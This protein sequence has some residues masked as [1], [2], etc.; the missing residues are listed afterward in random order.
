MLRMKPRR[1]SLVL[2][3]AL[4]AAGAAAVAWWRWHPL[5]VEVVHPQ[6]GTAIDAVYATGIV[7]PTIAVPIAPRVAGRIVS[8]NVDEGA[9]VRRGQVL[10]R[11]EDADLRR[12]QDELDAR[13]RYA[14]Q[15]LERAQTLLQRGLGSTADRDKALSDSQAADAAAARNREQLGF[16]TLTAPANGEVIR[17]DGEVGQYIAVNQPIFQLA[18]DAPLRISADVDEEDIAQVA[19]GQPVV[20][21]ADGFPDAVFDGAVAEITPKGDPTT[22]SYRVRIRLKGD[23]PLHIG[24]TT[25][26]NIIVQ[27]HDGVLLVPPSALLDGGVWVVRGERLER[28]AVRAGIEGEKG[29]EILAGLDEHDAVVAQP[30][31]SFKAGQRVRARQRAAAP[32]KAGGAGGS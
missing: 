1:G 20:I 14:R 26:A 15:A 2:L 13:A 29:V 25:D 8:L 4:L 22:R 9:R 23:T 10:A 12:A 16:M 3:I 30:L 6:R 21:H 18:T 7:E 32:G 31:E 19:I 24:M 17:R 28:R 11:L 5:T 27:R